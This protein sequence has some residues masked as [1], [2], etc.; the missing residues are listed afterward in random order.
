MR[1][2]LT[3][4]LLLFPLFLHAHELENIKQV[5]AGRQKA[6]VE[7]AS[8]QERSQIYYELAVA[9]YEDQEIDQAFFNFLEALKRQAKC[10]PLEM[11]GEEA[12]HYQRALE[13]YL[14]R[15][16]KDPVHVAEELLQEYGETASQNPNF[17]H[18]NFL[19]ATAYANLGKYDDFFHRFYRGYPYLHDTFLAYK[20]QGILY[21]R[22]AHHGKSFEER[23]CFQKEAVH[24]LSLALARNPQ[25]SGLYKVLIFLAK[26]EKKEELILSYLQKIVENKVSLPRSDIYLYVREAVAL[27]AFELGQAMIDHARALYDY[28]RAIAAA[29]EYL[30]QHRG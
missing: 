8:E 13:D 2:S 10:T 3:L 11:C 5:I 17:L 22:L 9:Y 27:K 16:G 12:L 20:T 24:C 26:D 1:K 28:S 18:L 4:F 21:L 14:T 15:V 23:G 29:Q 30:N 25:D 7:A 6:L 19:I